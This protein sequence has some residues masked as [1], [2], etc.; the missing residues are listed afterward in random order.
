MLG[1]AEEGRDRE[2]KNSERTIWNGELYLG[3]SLF[4]EPDLILVLFVISAYLVGQARSWRQSLTI[5]LAHLNLSLDFVTARVGI[6]VKVHSNKQLRLLEV[7]NPDFPEA[8]W[9]TLIHSFDHNFVLSSIL[10][11]RDLPLAENEC[12]IVQLYICLFMHFVAEGVLNLNFA[13]DIKI[14]VGLVS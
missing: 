10:F 8:C 11:L 5:W 3:F 13:F 9:N 7:S 14:R 6:L 12:S 4:V 2:G 1:K